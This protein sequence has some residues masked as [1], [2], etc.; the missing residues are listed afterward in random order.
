MNEPLFQQTVQAEAGFAYG[1]IGADLHVFQDA[2]P[3]YT[4]L[5]RAGPP[6]ADAAWLLEQ[7]SR[8]LDA[9]YEVVAFGGREAE[10]ADLTSWLEGPQ[11]AA[12]W[13]HGP[14]GQGKTR[15]VS[16]FADL[17]AER[18]WKVV[19]AVH[20]AVPSPG[21]QDLLPGA[22]PG[23]LLIVDYADRWP[24][25][26][27]SWLFA[28]ALL[29]APRTAR[30]LLVARSVRSWP[31]LRAVLTE[32]GARTGDLPLGPLPR[33]AIDRERVF[34]AARD[35]FC[36]RYG[37]AV[38]DEV[39]PPRLDGPGFELVL[40]LHMAALVAVDARARGVSPPGDPSEFSAYLLDRERRHWTELHGNQAMSTPPQVMARTVFTAVLTGAQ[41]Y[42]AA[43]GVLGG[44][45]LPGHPHELIDDHAVC[46]PPAEP[47]RVLEP[48]YPDRLAEDL[49]A[50]ALP[51]HAASGGADPWTP[52][53]TAGLL[54][55]DG[56]PP[57]YAGR[58]ITFLASSATRWPHVGKSLADALSA[59]PALALAGGG[60][61]LTALAEV[62]GL[63]PAVLDAVERLF[64]ERRNIDLDAG[65]AA[66]TERVVAHRLATGVDPAM[67]AELHA[68]LARRLLVVDRTQDA[69]THEERAVEGYRALVEEDPAR[70]TGPLAIN[71]N[72]LANLLLGT[73]RNEEAMSAVEE[74]VDLL[75]GLD[76]PFN[77]AMALGNRAILAFQLDRNDEAIESAQE[78]V[79][80]HRLAVAADPDDLDL[81][82]GLAMALGNL[83][84][85]RMTLKRGEEQTIEASQEAVTLSRWLAEADPDAFGHR[86]AAMLGT[87]AAQLFTVGR[88]DDGVRAAIEAVALA[89]ETVVRHPIRSFQSALAR[90]VVSLMGMYQRL[91]RWEEALAIGQEHLVAVRDFGGPLLTNV[92]A[93]MTTTLTALGR[94]EEALPY[95]R[96]TVERLRATV[97]EA[98]PSDPNAEAAARLELA[99]MLN[100]FVTL[101]VALRRRKEAVAAAGERVALYERLVQDVG[102]LRAVIDLHLA[103][104]QLA[105][106]QGKRRRA[107]AEAREAARLQEQIDNMFPNLFANLLGLGQDEPRRRAMDLRTKVGLVAAPALGAVAFVLSLTAG[108]GSLEA[109]LSGVAVA[110]LFWLARLRPR[111]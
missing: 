5:E 52:G 51:G 4:L 6:A 106:V 82:G 50:L 45:G 13:V 84:Y 89:R 90:N 17:A 69:V 53:A 25:S 81:Q 10:L 32:H 97:T 102:V 67:R 70:F 26:H 59:D 19:T 103:R 61:A 72:N 28:N 11:L 107:A 40:T 22:A 76:D 55:H 63:D 108:R 62:P 109:T 95:A 79:Q 104:E 111:G 85:L 42:E 16:A 86:V 12:R 99:Q 38:P 60:A 29:H 27:L 20:R 56:D 3:V 87:H 44:L 83:A 9:R 78:A 105:S 34:A 43:T 1:V 24:L 7:P 39:A 93:G 66:V 54:A 73:D 15:L 8:L 14:G 110:V 41:S 80:N 33:T 74:A 64:P 36:E 71:L 94:Q 65:I 2:G 35:C 98:D 49:L 47:D 23:L 77:L 31:A 100:Q 30:V 75:R 18:G 58:A 48:L 21:S 92:L 101:L 91:E 46:Y 57:A 88:H 68:T 37:L 96:E